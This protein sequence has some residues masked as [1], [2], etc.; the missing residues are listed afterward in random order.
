MYVKIQE[1]QVQLRYILWDKDIIADILMDRPPKELYSHG[2]LSLG[3]AGI[4]L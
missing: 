2:Y 1:T 4:L 3:K